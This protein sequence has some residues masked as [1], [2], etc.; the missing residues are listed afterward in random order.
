[1]KVWADRNRSGE[2]TADVNL[3]GTEDLAHIASGDSKGVRLLVRDNRQLL[4]VIRQFG[5]GTS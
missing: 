5:S 4:W 3:H 2:H 1:M